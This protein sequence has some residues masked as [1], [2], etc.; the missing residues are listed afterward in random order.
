MFYDAFPPYVPV[1]QRRAQAQRKISQLRKRGKTVSPVVIEGRQIAQ[2][3]WGKAWCEYL[4]THSDYASRLPRGRTYVRN[5]SVIDLQL[6]PGKVT[7]LVSGS[8]L[9]D[10]EI[11]IR[12]LP[13]DRW[14]QLVR[15]CVGKIDSVVELLSGKLSGGVMEV[16]SRRD[17][18]LFP[19]SKE[20][21]LSC[22]CPDGA[23]LCKHLAAV[24]YGIGARLDHQ[25]EL[26]FLLRG[27]EQADLVGE[28]AA[29]GV[30][31]AKGKRKNALKGSSLAGLFDI[32]L[33]S[34]SPAP[35]PKKPRAKK[36]V[37]KSSQKRGLAANQ[38]P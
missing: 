20:V 14:S 12:P 30:L 31:G 25:P 15:Q 19:S 32:E 3:F 23:Y 18:G 27:V 9:Y 22:S 34:G 29:G 36:A 4:E 33:D 28:V 21:S 8:S 17:T 26:L 1:A 24:L 7:A 37:Q 38:R 13:K 2:T 35:A 16:L 6:Q 10:V 5:G 11:E